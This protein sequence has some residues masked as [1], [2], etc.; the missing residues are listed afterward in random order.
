MEETGSIRPMRRNRPRQVLAS[1]EFMLGD[2]SYTNLAT[3][4]TSTPTISTGDYSGN[5]VYP[6][7]YDIYGGVMNPVS[8]QATTMNENY[9]HYGQEQV[10]IALDMLRNHLPNAFTSAADTGMQ[11]A[12]QRHTQALQEQI[13]VLRG[14]LQEMN[15]KYDEVL[16]RLETAQLAGQEMTA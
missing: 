14:E 7:G 6:T 16:Y 11:N 4:T 12:L 13:N 10:R 2:G 8:Q 9:D 3:T 5:V 1:D 15:T